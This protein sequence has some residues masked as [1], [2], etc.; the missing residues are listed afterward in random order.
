[1]QDARRS[2]IIDEDLE[3]AD[4]YS[5]KSGNQNF[6][7]T[8]ASTYRTSNFNSIHKNDVRKL[9]RERKEQNE[10]V[11]REF[12]ALESE[13]GAVKEKFE[14]AKTRNKVLVN[15]NKTLKDQVKTLLEKGKHDDELVE[16]LIVSFWD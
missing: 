16:A 5:V 15:E 9:E 7:V 2:Q 11:K 10:K 13:Y 6:S 4:D 8:S 1:M 3:F 12:E 14:A